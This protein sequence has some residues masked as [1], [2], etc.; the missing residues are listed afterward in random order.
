MK[1]PVHPRKNI[2]GIYDPSGSSIIQG[3]GEYCTRPLDM[4]IG[5]HEE[6]LSEELSPLPNDIL[7]YLPISWLRRHNPEIDWEVGTPQWRSPY[8]QQ[9]V[10]LEAPWLAA[11]SSRN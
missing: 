6:T 11:V 1:F 4:T 8:C 3:A 10:Q 5:K 7:G 2:V 9:D